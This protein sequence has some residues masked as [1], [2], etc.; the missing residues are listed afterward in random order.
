MISVV[1]RDGE[2]VDFNLVKISDAI[3][4]AFTATQKSYNDEIISL[5]SLRVTSDFQE[6]I[7]GDTISVEDIQ[8]SVEQVLTTPEPSRKRPKRPCTAK[9]PSTPISS[10]KI[11]ILTWT[12]STILR[13]GMRIMKRCRRHPATSHGGSTRR[14]AMCPVSKARWI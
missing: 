8:E 1:K 10:G 13:S 2:V 14:P 4:K 11:H 5:L 9:W 6:K 12:H 7:K 3:S